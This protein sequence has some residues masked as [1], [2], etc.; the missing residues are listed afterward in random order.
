ME[1]LFKHSELPNSSQLSQQLRKRRS[2]EMWNKIS[3]ENTMYEFS[4]YFKGCKL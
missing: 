4:M 3:E 1:T 2:Q